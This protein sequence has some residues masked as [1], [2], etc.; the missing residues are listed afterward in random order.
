[1]GRVIDLKQIAVN[2]LVIR[3][4]QVN[5]KTRSET[6]EIVQGPHVD[7]DSGHLVITVI[8]NEEGARGQTVTIDLLLYGIVMA[9]DT[10]LNLSDNN[11][12]WLET[13][14]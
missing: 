9:T 14:N 8:P 2:T 4:H 5:G 10:G 3:H 6:C 7:S 11:E 1:M 13:S 12:Y